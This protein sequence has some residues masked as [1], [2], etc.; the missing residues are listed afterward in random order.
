VPVFQAILAICPS[1]STTA[2]CLT[3]LVISGGNIFH[4]GCARNRHIRF[5]EGSGGQLKKEK[6][7]FFTI[8]KDT[9]I[10]M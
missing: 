9:S 10:S 6:S 1:S 4:G 5:G 8:G 2:I 7:R 3:L